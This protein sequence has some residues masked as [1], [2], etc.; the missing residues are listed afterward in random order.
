M[1]AQ[2][3]V[4]CVNCKSCMYDYCPGMPVCA[5]NYSMDYVTG[6]KKYLECKLINTSGECHL[7][8]RLEIPKEMPKKS[9]WKTL[10]DFITDC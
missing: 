10:R 7:F 2:N 1:E 8:E 3:K 9:L 5:L 4:F 6:K